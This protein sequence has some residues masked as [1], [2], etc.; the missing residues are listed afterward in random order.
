VLTTG[1]HLLDMANK[2]SFAVPAFN[3]SDWA[4]SQGIFEISEE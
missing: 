1:T 3:I 2:H 4:M